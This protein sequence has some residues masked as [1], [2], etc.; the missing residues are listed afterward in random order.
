M[1]DPVIQREFLDKFRPINGTGDTTVIVPR[2][3][4]DAV[5]A[6]LL[7]NDIIGTRIDAE[8][9]LAEELERISGNN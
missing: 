7:E 2:S 9:I 4:R 8:R 1:T 3:G 6:D 5:E